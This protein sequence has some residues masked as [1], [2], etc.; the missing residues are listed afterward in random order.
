MVFKIDEVIV[1]FPMILLCL[2]RATGIYDR[3]FKDYTE[4]LRCLQKLVKQYVCYRF[5]FH[6]SNCKNLILSSNIAQQ[7]SLRCKTH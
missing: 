5:A 2:F 6:T 3:I 1:S 7:Q 4:Y